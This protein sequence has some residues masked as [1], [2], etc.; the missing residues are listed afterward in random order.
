MQSQL[1][2]AM[3]ARVQAM[4]V[5]TPGAAP[6]PGTAEAIR[7]LGYLSG[8]SGRRAG[9]ID[10]KDGLVLLDALEAAKRLL[11]A[12]RAAEALPQLRALCEK[13]P[14]NVPFLGQLARAQED[15]GDRDGAVRTLRHARDLNPRSE[16]AHLHLADALRRKGDVGPARQ[17]YEDA[18]AL[19]P[20]LAAAWLA[21]AEMA[22]DKGA[23]EERALLARGAAAG[24]ES[25]ALLTRL[26]QLEL[27]AGALALAEGHLREATALTPDFPT[28]WLL[29]GAVAERQGRTADALRRYERAVRL[30]PR[31]PVALLHLGRLRL[32]Q[33]DAAAARGDARVRGPSRT[34][35]GAGARG[36]AAA[37]GA[38]RHEKRGRRSAPLERTKRP[39]YST[40]KP[41]NSTGCWLTETVA[42]AVPPF[43]SV[44]VYWK[45]SLQGSPQ[46]RFGV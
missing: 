15:A 9:T 26:A 35:L 30:A 24:T 14:G 4:T 20:R 8:A 45:L 23:A 19:N 31:D 13:S 21:L 34:R 41:C 27:S 17:G 12:G 29:W 44:T 28:A 40:L 33:G 25:A 2:A 16:F 36:G 6:D 1:L 3:D 46:V 11:D 38:V 18:L 22:K 42:V 43:W 7:A 39:G 32:A 10:P 37:R 5:R